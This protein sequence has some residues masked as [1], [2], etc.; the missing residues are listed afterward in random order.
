MKR[1]TLHDQFFGHLIEQESNAG[2]QDKSG[3]LSLQIVEPVLIIACFSGLKRL[4]AS[5]ADGLVGIVRAYRRVP[6]PTTGAF[7]SEGGIDTNSQTRY[8]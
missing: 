7:F 5:R 1:K 4:Q 6:Y 2:D 8:P 3:I